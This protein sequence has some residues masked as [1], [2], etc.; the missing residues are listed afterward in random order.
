MASLDE[1]TRAF[2]GPQSRVMGRLADVAREQGLGLVVLFGSRADGEVRNE[3]DWDL[4]VVP[5]S[6]LTPEGHLELV[7]RIKGLGT[8]AGLAIN[9]DTPLS[10][11]EHLLDN[12]DLLLIMTV[13]PGFGGQSF[14]E[15]VLPKIAEASRLKNERKL[16]FVIEVDG[17]ITRDNASAVREAGGQVLVA[18][19]AVFKSEDYQDSITAIRGR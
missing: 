17:G 4:A 12:L 2:K 18:G 16:G 10:D 1:E 14:I 13:F 8:G 7:E 6:R 19:T 5:G 15:G 11:I 3:S 9:P